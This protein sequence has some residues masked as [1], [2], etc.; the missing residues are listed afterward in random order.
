M[1]ASGQRFVVTVASGKGGTGKTTV[2]TSLALT[3]PG[4]ALYADC[5][6]EEPNGGL[7]LQPQIERREVFE[8]QVPTLHAERCTQCGTCQEVCAFQ[9][10]LVLGKPVVFLEQCHSC[11]ACIELCPE[12]ALGERGVRRGDLAFG[13]RNG[14]AFIEGRLDVGQVAASPLVRAVRRAADAYR[15]GSAGRY[16]VAD[17]SPGVACPVMTAALG[18]D[19]L[20]LVTEPTPLGAH[21]LDRALALG[22]TLELGSGIVLNRSGSG[23][24][25]LIEEVAARHGVPILARLPFDRRIAVAYAEGRLLVEACP[26]LEEQFHGLWEAIL[27]EGES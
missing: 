6:V 9:A 22:K 10:I 11:G 18:A 19:Y 5:D 20:L 14:L 26:E 16:V 21:D 23:D 2:A 8:S 15:N 3:A 17:A 4:P 12:G 1:T 25:A 24:D 27:G 7:F 13:R